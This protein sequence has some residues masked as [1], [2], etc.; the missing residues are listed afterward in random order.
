MEEAKER[1]MKKNLNKIKTTRIKQQI[2]EAKKECSI[3]HKLSPKRK[4]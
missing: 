1:K 4:S 2:K 3:Y